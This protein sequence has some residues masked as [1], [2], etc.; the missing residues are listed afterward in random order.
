MFEFV[1]ILSQKKQV[2]DASNFGNIYIYELL[3]F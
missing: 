3:A 1:V 2:F